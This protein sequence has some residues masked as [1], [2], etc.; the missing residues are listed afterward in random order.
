MDLLLSGGPVLVIILVISLYALYVFFER[1]LKLSRERVRA[2]ALMVRVG[3]ALRER[4]LELALISCEDHGGPVARVL[5]GA[6]SRLPYGKA[7]VEAAFG[8]ASLEEEQSLTQGLRA[9][10]T[11]AQIAPLLGLLGTVTGMI[12]AFGQ[13]S[14]SGVGNAATLAGGIGQALVTT[15]AGLIVAIPALIGHNYLSSK[16]DRIFLEIDRRREELMGMVAQIASR[17]ESRRGS[18]PEVVREP[19]V[20]EP[21][22]TVAAP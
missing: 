3:E 12:I 22:E 11:I 17:R 7:A 13:I 9:L 16:V 1:L 10:S 4:N 19:V 20:R 5:H 6:L 8:E 2:D 21:Y 14:V 18:A 15:A